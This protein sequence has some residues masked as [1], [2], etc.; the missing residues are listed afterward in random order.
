MQAH[1]RLRRSAKTTTLMYHFGFEPG[2][3]DFI[4][5]TAR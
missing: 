5:T 4:V 1:C 3:I 2:M